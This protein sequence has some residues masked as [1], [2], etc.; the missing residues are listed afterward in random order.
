M[1]E[2]FKLQRQQEMLMLSSSDIK[3]R[4]VNMKR[5]RL[6]LRKAIEVTDHF[7]MYADAILE[8]RGDK[9]DE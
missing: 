7:L 1:D 2:A 3:K 8:Q 6:E 4:I 9:D 5:N